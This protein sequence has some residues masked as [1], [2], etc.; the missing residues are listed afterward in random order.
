[1]ASLPLDELSQKIR[2]VVDL[3]SALRIENAALQ[4]DL[5]E[6]RRRLAQKERKG[7]VSKADS[8]TGTRLRRELSQ[9]RKERKMVRRKV[10]DVLKKLEAVQLQDAT[11]QPELFLDD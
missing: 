6:I 3:V 8:E 11:V 4:G 9:L 1:M 5:A 10:S 7:P 2:D